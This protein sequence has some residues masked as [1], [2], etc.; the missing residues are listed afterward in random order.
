MLSVSMKLQQTWKILQ[1]LLSPQKET[2]SA[3]L[4]VEL[5]VFCRINRFMCYQLIADGRLGCDLCN[6]S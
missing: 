5:C 4:N 6:V 3:L 2:Q 1:H